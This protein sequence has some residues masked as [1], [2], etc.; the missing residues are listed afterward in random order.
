MIT[1]SPRDSAD[2]ANSASH[3]GVRW[4]ETIWHS[5]AIEKSLSTRSACCIVSQS[6]FEPMITA[7]SGVVAEVLVMRGVRCIA[8]WRER[9][10]PEQAGRRNRPIGRVERLVVDVDEIDFLHDPP[11]HAAAV[12]IADAVG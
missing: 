7:T 2:V 12:E 4:A 1:C 8:H 3:A 9:H 6:D 5:W 10:G 11:R